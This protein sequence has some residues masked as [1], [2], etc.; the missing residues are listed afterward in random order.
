MIRNATR[1]KQLSEDILDV[2]I[3]ESQSLNLRKEIFDLNN[4]YEIA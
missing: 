1:L 4:L 2:T 3:I